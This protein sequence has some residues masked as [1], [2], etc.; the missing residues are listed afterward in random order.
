MNPPHISVVISL[1]NEV[2][3]LPELHRQL[4]ETLVAN[5]KPYELLFIDD[6]SRDGS[7]ELLKKLCA[8]DLSSR[9][10]SLRL[11]QGKSAALSVGFAA[12]QGDYVITMDADLQDNPAEIPGMIAK[13]DEGYDLVSGW[14]KVRHDPPA[15][16]IPS[17]FFNLVTSWAAGLR[18]HDFN[19]GL[20]AYRNVVVKD[21]FV[22]GEL[23]RFLP[24]L[25]HKMGYRCTEMVVMHRPRE[26][27][28]SK[29]GMSRF[30]NGF[31]DLMTVMFLFGFNRAP[32]HFFGFIGLI[33]GFAGLVIN[34]YL[35]VLKFGGQSIGS[36][37]LLFLGVLLLVIGVQ[38]FS[39]GLIGEMLAH[40]HEKK[41]VYPIEFDSSGSAV[42]AE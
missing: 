21:L 4:S 19:C 39:F 1:F 15:K 5:G 10:I 6:G 8:S 3:S 16:T 23:H 2:E 27:G 37:P 14:K 24:V 29:F 22:Y 18:L 34:L 28:K 30:L 17:K 38:F 36:R 11:N 12:A 32:L 42:R 40:A 13:L 25:A 9:V 26:F 33:C 31:L 20:K 7:L 35:T 41:R